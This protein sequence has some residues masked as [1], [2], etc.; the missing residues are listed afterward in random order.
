MRPEQEF[1]QDVYPPYDQQR[2][3]R[4]GGYWKGVHRRASFFHL[5]APCGDDVLNTG[6]WISFPWRRNG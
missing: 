2:N 5:T 4:G 3:Y 1:E 6:S